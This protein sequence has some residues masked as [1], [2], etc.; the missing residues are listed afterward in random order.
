M[1][2]WTVDSMTYA[3]CCML[4]AAS[5]LAFLRA[6]RTRTGIATSYSDEC[7]IPVLWNENRPSSP[8]TSSEMAENVN[9]NATASRPSSNRLTRWEHHRLQQEIVWDCLG[10]NYFSF[11]LFVPT[12]YY[13]HIAGS[14]NLGSH[15][16]DSKEEIASN[17][18][19][20]SS[21]GKQPAYYRSN[22]I[23]D[24]LM[25]SCTTYWVP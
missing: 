9:G 5:T 3:V 11:I 4:H 20:Q 8:Q 16:I 18:K 2:G 12:R 6:T 13:L 17:N 22:G 25:V 7:S 14:I 15:T 21:K 23:G 19:I 1:D 10:G 24:G